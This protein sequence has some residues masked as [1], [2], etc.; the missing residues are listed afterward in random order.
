MVT[1]S[2]VQD[3]QQ[4]RRSRRTWLRL[5]WA[6]LVVL[7]I[8]SAFALQDGALGAAD[9]LVYDR[10]M[11]TIERPAPPDVVI[12]AI[13][14]KSIAGL[15]RW[16][17]KRGLHAQLLNVLN[18]GAPRAV[19][20]DLL[21]TEPDTS[22]SNSNSGASGD[23]A[24]AAALARNGRTILPILTTQTDAGIAARLPLA[25]LAAAAAGLAH[26]Q[27]EVG[28]DG[29]V[30][31][32]QQEQYLGRYRTR[33]FGVALY[34]LASPDAIPDQQGVMRIPF[35]G[36]AGHFRQVSYIDVLHG[37]VPA[38]F[39]RDKIVL[40]GALAAGLG[41]VYAV[42][43]G[44]GQ[45]LMSGVEIHAN[46]V[47]ALL[48]G[49]RITTPP[50][51]IAI[52][53]TALP[54]LLVLLGFSFLAPRSALALTAGLT[55]LVIL[56]CTLLFG[57]GLWLPPSA[58]LLL[59]WLVY[60]LWSWRR[61]ESALRYLDEETR[62]LAASAPFQARP[63]G[64]QRRWD[65]LER[66]IDAARA[67]TRRMLDLHQFVSDNLDSLPDAHLV[68]SRDGQLMLANR[69]AQELFTPLGHPPQRG[70]RLRDLLDALAGNTAHDW[71]ALLLAPQAPG[72]EIT[73]SQG[74]VFALR[75]TASHDGRGAAIGW[76][77]SLAELTE[78]RAA[79][80]QRDQS[81]NFISHDM[82]APQ[83]SILATLALHRQGQVVLDQ[84]TLFARIEKAV[85]STLSLADDFVLLARAQSGHVQREQAQL[86]SLLADAADAL[87]PLARERGAR[88]DIASDGQSHW[89]M[90]E[91]QM[92]VR[93]LGN[94][95]SNAIKYGPAGGRIDCHVSLDEDQVVCRIDDE[96][97][98]LDD[99]AQAFTPFYR[100]AGSGQGGA[101]LGLSFVRTVAQLHGGTASARNRAG[102]GASFELRLPAAL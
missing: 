99:D 50:R 44:V 65:F 40:V 26:A 61:L 71:Q 45:A 8:V 13:D 102:G 28:A 87:W 90:G 88:I 63:P 91:H 19:G 15:G 68:A 83:S 66:R 36:P 98:G 6:L 59:L 73:D 58:A 57:H 12:V 86:D 64:S 18:N 3:Q 4:I 48:E 49:R 30:R 96:G 84:E 47:A 23:L 35:F 21:L 24:L 70:Q 16:P 41:D 92:L 93:A 60:P 85:R 5:Q 54:A 7:T 22:G 10:L 38:S 25:P 9:R 42:P 46:V 75:G 31:S 51:G 77:I 52:A 100:A 53:F 37:L 74:R 29:R 62:R 56:A 81:L 69:K 72:L 17:W 2:G 94:L 33:A 43:K 101:G 78:L 39:F 32:V 14:D 67:A 80:T 89:V 95:L 27:L 1:E 55:V 34:R 11:R 20:L 82:R 79:Q 76:I 97:P